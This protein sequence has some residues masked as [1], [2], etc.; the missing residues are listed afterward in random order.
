[1]KRLE[2]WW[3]AFRFHYTSASFMPGILGAMIAWTTDS[4]FHPGLFLLVMLGLILNHMALN[5]TDDYYDFR[6][7]VDA[8]A[9]E[10]K[11]PYAGGSGTLSDGLI[12]PRRMRQVFSTFYIIAIGIGLYLG[13]VR[14]FFVVLLL[15]FGFFCAFF[16]TAP[17]IRF[18][19]RGL[20]EMAQLLCF[21]P[22]VGLGAYYVQAQR[23]SWEAFWGTL[24]FGIML[25][26]MITI[27]EI[28]DYFEDRKGGKLNLVARFGRET[29][30]WLFIV[31]LLSA[32][33]VILT[34]V[35]LRRIPPLG[36]ISL[37]TL[38]IAY[39]TIS[40]LRAHYQEPVKM[41]PANLGM[42]CCHNFT[43]IL[44]ALSYFIEGF[45]SNALIPSLLPAI[46][47][48]ILYIPIARLI[49]RAVFTQEGN[50]VKTA[51]A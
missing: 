8:F 6:H 4:Q 45:R 35:L 42:I 31:S 39:K 26:S 11:N 21:G 24:P 29:G 3:R 36:L 5:M 38:P 18:G 51:T 40:V 1:L 44:L 10:D 9:E 30:V 33:G 22:G 46:V 28:P 34:G 19:Y 2:I 13:M 41:A 50:K 32:Y 49:G 20:G 25:F 12:Q 37:L 15:A 47:L 14:G 43:A 23:I 7:L 17:P 48:T 16:Y 27:N